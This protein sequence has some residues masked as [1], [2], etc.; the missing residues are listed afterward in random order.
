MMTS[1]QSIVFSSLAVLNNQYPFSIPFFPGPGFS[2]H[3]LLRGS[4]LLS[5][6]WEQTVAICIPNKMLDSSA[7]SLKP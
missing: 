6:R 5:G 1:K 4:L 2:S 3:S 7:K